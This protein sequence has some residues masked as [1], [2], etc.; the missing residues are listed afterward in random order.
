[1]NFSV[2]DL[3]VPSIL[4]WSFFYLNKRGPR[5]IKE[6]VMVGNS[7]DKITTEQSPLESVHSLLKL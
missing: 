1:M 3:N 6:R 4:F 7:H 5:T 2:F